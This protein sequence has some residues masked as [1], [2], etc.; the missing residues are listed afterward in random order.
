MDRGSHFR[1]TI[2]LATRYVFMTDLY[3]KHSLS[4]LARS[5]KRRGGGAVESVLERLPRMR[6][7]CCS[8]LGCDG[9]NSSKQVVTVPLRCLSLGNS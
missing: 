9:R 2:F 3:E 8:N 4:H 7:V 1:K 5:H 6:K